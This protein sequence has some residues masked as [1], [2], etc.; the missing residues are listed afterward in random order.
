[1]DIIEKVALRA[2]GIDITPGLIRGS[3]ALVAP[4][5]LRV[6]PAWCTARYE[7][8]Y[9][10]DPRHRLNIF[11]PKPVVAR[12]PVLLFVHGGGFV[13]GN[14]GGPDGVF[15]NNVGA[16]AAR[17]GYVGVTMSYR[18]APQDVWPA[19]SD[20]VAAAVRW[21]HANEHQHGGDPRGIFVMG[22]SAG[23]AH[24]ASFVAYP[25]YDAVNLIRGAVLMSGIYDLENL[26]LGP[27]E[28]AYYGIDSS[29]FNNQSS[30]EGLMKTTLPCLYTVSEQD[31]ETFQSQAYLVIEAHWARR[32]TLP[33]MLYLSGHNHMSPAL[34]L[35][36]DDGI[37]SQEIADFM[38]TALL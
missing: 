32:R 17:R 15:Y 24:V 33:R 8:S 38:Q 12:A 23:A 28:Q 7:V 35:G 26:Q 9:G 25:R 27:H 2:L 14:K 18:L 10:T 22:Q 16:W 20:D 36:L 30:L 6:D 4:N 37:L 34:V 29:H 3:I 31:P 1:M 21:L 5:A 11:E 13:G 19:G